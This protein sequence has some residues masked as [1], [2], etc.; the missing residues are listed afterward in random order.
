MGCTSDCL[1]GGIHVACL[2]AKL[3]RRRGIASYWRVPVS[4]FAAPMD[5]SLY[6]SSAVMNQHR[7]HE[8]DQVQD[9]QESIV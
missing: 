6:R 5:P 2:D 8:G 9:D 4:G 3:E 7:G 1:N